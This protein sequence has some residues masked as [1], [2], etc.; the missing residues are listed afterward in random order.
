MNAMGSGFW[1]AEPL[2]G[3]HEPGAQPV[4]RRGAVEQ[5]RVI[6][7]RLS[8]VPD[9]GPDALDDPLADVMG[10]PFSTSWHDGQ[11]TAEEPSS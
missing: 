11:R 5:D 8:S 3:R 10:E 7:D 2:T 6:L 4:G 1:L 9:L